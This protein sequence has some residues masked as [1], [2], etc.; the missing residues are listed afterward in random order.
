M[1]TVAFYLLI[2][3]II[4]AFIVYIVI[5][6]K[7][8]RVDYERKDP[9]YCIDSEPFGIPNGFVA[10]LWPFWVVALIICGPFMLCSKFAKWLKKAMNPNKT[11]LDLNDG[12][13][14]SIY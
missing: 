13:K 11:T 6:Y 1:N 7:N 3:Y 2:A 9:V 5:E 8:L 12:Q 10:L 14:N 4:I